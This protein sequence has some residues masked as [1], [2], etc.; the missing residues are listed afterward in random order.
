MDDMR[1]MTIHFN[2]GSEMR[3]DFIIQDLDLVSLGKAIEKAVESNKLVLE[4]EGVMYLFPYENI[5]YVRVSPSPEMLP[6]I[7]VKGVRLA[8]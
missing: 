2:D 4:V 1:W 8:D 5:K 3:F 6:E 7:A